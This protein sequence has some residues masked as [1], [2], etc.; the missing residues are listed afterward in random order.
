MDASGTGLI[1]GGMGLAIAS[2]LKHLDISPSAP[3]GATQAPSEIE[4]SSEIKES[5]EPES[6]AQDGSFIEE[7]SADIEENGAE[8]VEDTPRVDVSLSEQTEREARTF[9]I[10]WPWR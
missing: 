1:L 9:G 4:E 6:S 3:K 5:S 8:T 7:D 10:R 2:N